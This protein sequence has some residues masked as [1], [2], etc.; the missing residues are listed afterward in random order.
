MLIEDFSVE[1][2]RRVVFLLGGSKT[3]RPDGFAFSFFQKYWNLLHDDLLAL[4][5]ESYSR[6]QDME[7][8]NYAFI[9][10]IPKE[11]C[12]LIARDL[13]LISL[14]KSFYKVISKVLANRWAYFFPLLVDEA[15]ST[16]IKGHSII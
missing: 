10:L 4:L 9:I 5:K 15:Q 8:L 14:I 13:R 16:L 6:D 12:P 7:R 2:I 3:T 1:E 11:E